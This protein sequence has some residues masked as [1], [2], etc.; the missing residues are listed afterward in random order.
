MSL[1]RRPGLLIP[2]II[3]LFLLLSPLLL[4]PTGGVFP[5]AGTVL[6]G[7][8][9]GQVWA[10]RRGRPQRRLVL[11]GAGIAACAL[12]TNWSTVMNALFIMSGLIVAS[13]GVAARSGPNTDS[14]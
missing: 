10:E 9:S 8:V 7:W 1:V 12:W 5:A 11:L 13:F 2:G 6:V 14:D 4:F 3:G